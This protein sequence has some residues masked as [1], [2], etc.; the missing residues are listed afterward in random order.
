[1]AR[2]GSPA[3]ANPSSY[4]DETHKTPN[5]LIFLITFTENEK[6]KTVFIPWVNLI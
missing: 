3:L 2:V 5:I 1:L 4:G 6:L